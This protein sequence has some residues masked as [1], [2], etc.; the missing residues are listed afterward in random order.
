M[1]ARDVVGFAGQKCTSTR[2]VLVVGS[3][4]EFSDALLAAMSALPVGDPT[5]RDVVAG[6]VVSAAAAAAVGRAVDACGPGVVRVPVELASPYVAP[7]LVRDDQGLTHAAREEVFGPVVVV[8]QVADVDDAVRIANDVPARLVAAVHTRD[9]EHAL[10]VANR[11][12]AGMV[13]VNA[14][15]TGVDLHAAFGGEGDSGYGP[16]EQGRAADALFTVERTITIRS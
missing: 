11:L 15:S 7:A 4:D 16:R 14:P 5:R 10:S 3:A 13:R 1:V 6:P 8:Q 9:L 12:R 2:R